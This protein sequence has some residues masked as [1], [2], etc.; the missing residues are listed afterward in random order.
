MLKVVSEIW[1]ENWNVMQIEVDVYNKLI[2]VKL[3]FE[4][5]VLM[6]ND[7]CKLDMRR[8]VTIGNCKFSIMTNVSFCVDYKGDFIAAK[9]ISSMKEEF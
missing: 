8:R 7:D 6:F 4:T 5:I 9:S 2:L 1:D 3:E